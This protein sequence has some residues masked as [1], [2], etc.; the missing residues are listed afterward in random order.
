MHGSRHNAIS[1]TLLCLVCSCGVRHQ[2]G[3]VTAGI[4]SVCDIGDSWSG[5]QNAALIDPH[6]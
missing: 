1:S 3:K 6:L 2:K 5:M 4:D